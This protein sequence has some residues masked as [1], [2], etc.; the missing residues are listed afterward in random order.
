MLARLK[1]EPTI[2]AHWRIALNLA[3]YCGKAFISSYCQEIF[4]AVVSNFNTV[5]TFLFDKK[6]SQRSRNSLPILHF[7]FRHLLACVKQLFLLS[8]YYT[9]GVL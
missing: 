6:Y 4:V 9:G 1:G 7:C 8:K 2:P 5:I 3:H